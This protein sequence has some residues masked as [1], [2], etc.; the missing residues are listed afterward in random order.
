MPNHPTAKKE[1]KMKRK[2]AAAIP[3]LV[4]TTE[5]V[6][7]SIAIDAACP[8]APNSIKRRRPNFSMVKIAIQDAMKYSVPLQAASSRLIKPDKPMLFSKIVAA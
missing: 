1:L 6:P 4:P 7:A 5:V 8:A 2:A 3:V